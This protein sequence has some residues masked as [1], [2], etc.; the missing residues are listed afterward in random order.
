MTKQNIAI[1]TLL[2]SPD[3]LPGIFTLGY[4]LSIL[5]RETNI[6][7]KIILFITPEV[8]DVAL[9]ELSLKLINNIFDEVITIRALTAN[10]KIIRKNKKNLQL[11]ER[12]ELAYALIK[13]R[14]WEQEQFDQ[15]LYLDADTLPLNNS[16]FDVFE[17]TKDQTSLQIA[18][19]PDIGWP[20]LFNSGVMSIIPD[21]QIAEDLEQFILNEISIDGA[22]Q[23]ILNQFFNPNCRKNSKEEVMSKKDWIVLPFLYNVTTPN[24]GYQCPP[25]LNFFRDQIKLIH[26]IGKTKPWKAWTSK[27]FISNEYT[28]KWHSIYNEFCEI[29]EIFEGYRHKAS[30]DEGCLQESQLECENITHE[31]PHEKQTMSSQSENTKQ[32]PPPPENLEPYVQ[33]DVIKKLEESEEEQERESGK[34]EN[35]PPPTPVALPLDF[36]EWLTTFISKEELQ[37][38]QQGLQEE[39][40]NSTLNDYEIQNYNEVDEQ[41]PVGHEEHFENSGQYNET[42]LEEIIESLTLDEEGQIGDSDMELQSTKSTALENMNEDKPY[43]E[44]TPN[45]LFDWEI[46]TNYK[47]HVERTFPDDIFEY[48]VEESEVEESEIE[49]SE[50]EEYDEDIDDETQLSNRDDADVDRYGEERVEEEGETTM[51]DPIAEIYSK[52]DKF[53]LC[54]YIDIDTNEHK[55]DDKKRVSSSSKTEFPSAS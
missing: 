45:F 3:Y 46:D 50:I 2:Y 51:Q 25:A 19:S 21:R 53:G 7:C 22:D 11:L 43:S 39:E 37:V 48:E 18:A 23:G 38:Q 29:N 5:I 31:S 20:D 4:Q 41:Q 15:I 47:Q 14:I 13:A 6:N 40:H 49:E 1:A 27:T 8:K 35:S 17:I 44:P 24:N 36:K 33:Q 12:P 42:P 52:V 9:T 55:T 28:N 54:D 34:A 26:F 16:L 10:D 30:N 32:N